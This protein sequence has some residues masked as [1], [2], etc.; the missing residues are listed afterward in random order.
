MEP[1]NNAMET[2]IVSIGQMVMMPANAELAV[3]DVF[4][5][6]AGIIVLPVRGP[7]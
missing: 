7:S 5:A 6:P 4:M 1:V 3:K 2:A